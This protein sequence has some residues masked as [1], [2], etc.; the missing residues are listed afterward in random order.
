MATPSTPRTKIF[1]YRPAPV[2]V[3]FC[4]YPGSMA[5]PFHQYMIADEVIVPEESEIYYSE[6]VL[7]IACN[8]PLDRKRIIAARPSRQE[9]GLPEDTLC[10]RLL[11]RHAEDHTIHLR[12]VD[13]HFERDA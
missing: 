6:K 12:A 13:A 4:G 9:A 1:A 8:Q 10:L 2:I 3:N 11:Q 7:R 5:T